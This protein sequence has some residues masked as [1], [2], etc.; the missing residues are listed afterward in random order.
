MSQNWPKKGQNT[1]FSRFCA[2]GCIPQ[3]IYPI[4]IWFFRECGYFVI[5]R[6]FTRPLDRPRQKYHPPFNFLSIPNSKK[7]YIF[8]G[9]MT[10]TQTCSESLQNQL[11][12]RSRVQNGS[13]GSTESKK[14]IFRP[15]PA[16][17]PAK[18]AGYWITYIGR[19]GRKIYFLDSVGPEDPF[20]T[21]KRLHNSFCGFCE[22][23]WS[24]R[25][26]SHFRA[27]S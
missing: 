25:I 22:S 15:I 2:F 13:P 11:W 23:R 4:G 20:C 1:C 10:N 18:S 24:W 5:Y 3:K 8:R 19:I 17:I 7:L 16:E 21:L 12:K 6:I 26:L 9:K 14:Y 27:D